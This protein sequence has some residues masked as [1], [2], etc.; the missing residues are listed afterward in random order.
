[1]LK[2]ILKSETWTNYFST[3][4]VKMHLVYALMPYYGMV[5]AVDTLADVSRILGG[6]AFH[7]SASDNPNTM[8]L[9]ATHADDN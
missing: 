9:L 7:S 2:P 5:C 1:M 4:E 8:E 6:V 3:C